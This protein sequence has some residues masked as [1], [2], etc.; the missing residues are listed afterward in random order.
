MGTTLYRYFDSEGQLLYV[1]ITKN[2]FNRLQDHAKIQPWWH[3]VVTGTFSHYQSREEALDAETV[4]I[5]TEMPKYNLAGP[6]LA[7]E[8][9]LHLFDFLGGEF[10]DDW[11]NAR[12]QEF[13]KSMFELMQF[14]KAKKLVKTAYALS[15]ATVYDEAIDDYVFDCDDCRRIYGSKWYQYTMEKADGLICDEAGQFF[16][17]GGELNAAN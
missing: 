8:L 10:E 13:N 11:H 17:K 7:P 2:Q 9:K 12:R 5:A 16:A 4:T 15:V 14:S 1:G 6:T 3:E